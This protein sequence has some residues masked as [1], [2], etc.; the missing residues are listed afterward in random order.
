MNLRGK[1]SVLAALAA[2]AIVAA[3]PGTAAATPDPPG[4][5]DNIAYDPSIPTFKQYADAN[6]IANN[7][8]GGGSTGTAN[9][10]PS[11]E[12]YGYFDAVMAATAGNPRVSVIRGDL[13]TSYLGKPMRYYVVGSTNNI[14]NLNAGRNDGEFWRG[15]REGTISAEEGALEAQNRPAFIWNTAT[16]HG[17]EPAAGE[18][19]SRV[20]YELTARTD[21]ANLQR[22]DRLDNFLMPVTNPDGRDANLRTTAYGFDPNRDFASR[23]QDVNA[24]RVTNGSILYPGPVYIDA[25]QQTSG[26]FFPPNEDPALHE[27]SNFLLDLIQNRIGP[28]L[29]QK[30]NDQTAQYRNY[31]TYDLFAIEYGDSAPALQLGAAGMTFEKGTSENYGKQVYDHY[32][33]M[34][35][36]MNVI[37]DDKDDIMAEWSEQWGEAREQG[38]N[39]ELQQNRL[40]SPLTP[41]IIQEPNTDV[42]GYYY[43]PNNHSGDTAKLIREMR[44]TGV[45]VYRFDESVNVPAAHD[46]ATDHATP[47][48]GSVAGLPSSASMTLPA[49]TLYIPMDQGAK[50]WIQGVLGEDPFIPVPYFYDVVD[51]SF[52]QMRGMSGN[53]FLTQALPDGVDMTEVFEADYGAVTDGAKPVLA[54]PTDSAQGQAMLIEIMSQGATVSRSEAAFSA[55]GKSFPTGTALVDNSTTSGIDM[56]ALSDKR[57]TPIMGLD[58]YPVARKA[59]IKPKIALYTGAATVPTNP[60][61]FGGAAVG[62]CGTTGQTAF[63]AM[64]HALAVNLGL[65]YQGANQVLYPITQTQILAGDLV[66]GNYTAMINPGQN[67][68]VAQ[69]NAQLQAFVNAGGRYVGDSA[70]GTTTARTAG[71][72]NLNTVA[73]NVAP[74]N[75]QCYTNQA[76]ALQTPGTMF[77]AEFDTTNPVAWGFDNGGFIYRQ[78][79][80]SPVYNPSTLAAVPANPPTVP[81]AIPATNVAINYATPT[82]AFGY[83]CNATGPGELEG[84]PYAT[85]STFGAGHSTVLG[86]DPWYRSWV[87]IEWRMALNG[88]LYPTGS[89]IPAGP[90]R[91]VAAKPASEPIAKKAL[92][93]VKDRPVIKMSAREDARV[94]VDAGDEAQVKSL[95]RKADVPRSARREAEWVTEG[96]K[97]V[98]VVRKAWLPGGELEPWVFRLGIVTKGS[99]FAGTNI[100]GRSH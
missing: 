91:R 49:G 54:F 57:Q 37:S 12:L 29:Q 74:F 76:S 80:N 31:N 100:P 59:L 15:V 77:L 6:A 5:T 97:R 41:T 73:T 47:P 52:S 56:A 81:N 11:L 24:T 61:G 32:L 55:G 26:Y 20:L 94:V 18:A 72:T 30:F 64:L 71:F 44:E 93:K 85:D 50:H 95:L 88:A 90:P 28:A 9:R 96:D 43:L 27:M 42:F 25:H 60:L 70:N 14:A 83:S 99:T 86:S 17:N 7:S 63:C 45:H 79:S 89:S 48:S 23:N 38:E 62:H 36:T 4:C 8:L 34:D 53:G 33:A 51:W 65:P 16:P 78:A 1:L 10:H 21:C 3:A 69:G 13:G 40:V 19:I 68:T 2:T 67:L 84:R 46:F 98:W 39:G 58:A 66:S 87:D 35:E 22:L 92:P 82:T 75:D